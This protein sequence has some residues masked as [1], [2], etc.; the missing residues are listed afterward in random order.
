GVSGKIASGEF[1]GKTAEGASF[2]LKRIVRTSP[3]MGAKPPPG[4]I[5][6]FDGGNLDAWQGAHTDERGLLASGSKTK[7][8]FQDFALHVEFFLPFKPLGRGQGRGNS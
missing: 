4:A 8:L 7:Q 1:K 5:V 3:A 2:T 6:L